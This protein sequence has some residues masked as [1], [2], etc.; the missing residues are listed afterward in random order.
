MTNGYES[1]WRVGTAEVST[2]PEV[3]QAWKEMQ[4]EIKKS[5]QF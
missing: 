3:E 1:W 4:T 2:N 5:R